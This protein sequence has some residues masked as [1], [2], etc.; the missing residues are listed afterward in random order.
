MISQ[1]IRVLR[2]VLPAAASLALVSTLLVGCSG[3]PLYPVHRLNPWVWEQWQADEQYA[4]TLHRQLDEV[5]DVRDRAASM[6]GPQQV[7]WAGEFRYILEHHRQPLLREAVVDALAEFAVPQADEALKV[8]NRDEDSVVRIAA[9]A[10]WGMR[11]A[12]DGVPQLTEMLGRDT[13]LDVRLAAAREI[14]RF[15]S[16]EAIH[17]LGLALGEPNVDPA[18]ENRV[19]ESLKKATGRD[20]GRDTHAW[21]AFV[22]GRDPGPEYTPSLAERMSRLF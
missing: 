19:I 9:C 14:G 16:P 22:Q 10:A 6:S 3:D 8:A 11:P 12:A 21:L 2:G 13:D 20:Y 5:A 4:P 18:L 7:H 17:A 1:K 15:R